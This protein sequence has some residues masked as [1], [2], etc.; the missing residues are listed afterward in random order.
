MQIMRRNL[1]RYLN[2]N[3]QLPF[4]PNVRKITPN[5]AYL[6]I[7]DTQLIRRRADAMK[8]MIRSIPFKITFMSKALTVFFSVFFSQKTITYVQICFEKLFFTDFF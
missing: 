1:L 7:L 5:Y 3:Y 4:M 8:R 6:Q 2:G